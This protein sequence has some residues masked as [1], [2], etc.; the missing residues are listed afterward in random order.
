M[1]PKAYHRFARHTGGMLRRRQRRWRF[2]VLSAAI[3]ALLIALLFPIVSR[4]WRAGEPSREP[5]VTVS[6]LNLEKRPSPKPTAAPSL[7]RPEATPRP[8]TPVARAAPVR[9]HR[10]RAE[11]APHHRAA[12][13]RVARLRSSELAREQAA[14]AQTIASA[15]AAQDPVA[16]AQ[17]K[18]VP[19][20]PRAYGFAASSISTVPSAGE[21]YLSPVRRWVTGDTVYYY[22]RYS[23]TY[24][25]GTVETGIVP[26]P[27]HFSLGHDPFARGIHSMPLPGPA[28]DYVASADTDMHPLVKNCYDHRYDYCPIAREGQT[29]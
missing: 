28:P 24:P 23:V 1:P 22:V 15:K 14:F 8:L 6:V 3:H 7:P 2:L 10:A 25:D 16:G 9:A 12:P 26:W 18:I 5:I 11:A 20:A 4:K 29:Q 19:A 17:T 21:G 27:I 13:E